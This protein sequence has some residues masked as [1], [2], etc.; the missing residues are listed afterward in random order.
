M[1]KSIYN[2]L[3]SVV[4]SP[5]YQINAGVLQD[6]FLKYFIKKQVYTSAWFHFEE[7]KMEQNHVNYQNI[8]AKNIVFAEGF[9]CAI[10]RFSNIYPF[11]FQKAKY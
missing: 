6:A 3:K 10:T 2:P 9:Y 5:A 1:P 8:Q 11:S 4:F 7:L